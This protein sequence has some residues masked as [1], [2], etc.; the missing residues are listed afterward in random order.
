MTL[1]WVF[2][3]G[4]ILAQYHYWVIRSL[5]YFLLQAFHSKHHE[6]LGRERIRGNSNTIMAGFFLPNQLHF[7]CSNQAAALS[8]VVFSHQ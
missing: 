7:P 3:L 4:Q 2:R 1:D 8:P 5:F 6:P